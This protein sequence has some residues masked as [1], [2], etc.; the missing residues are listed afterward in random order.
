MTTTTPDARVTPAMLA[1]AAEAENYEV[2]I[3]GLVITCGLM[4]TCGC[5]V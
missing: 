1:A 2:S 4:I 3:P 5:V